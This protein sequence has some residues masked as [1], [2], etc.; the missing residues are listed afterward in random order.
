VDVYLA[1]GENPPR[2][3]IDSPKKTTGTRRFHFLSQS[4]ALGTGNFQILLK[5][6]RVCQWFAWG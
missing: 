4:P 1:T 6:G 2:N 5:K 3:W